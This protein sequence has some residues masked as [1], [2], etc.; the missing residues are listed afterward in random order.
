MHAEPA[1]EHPQISQIPQILLGLSPEPD[2][3]TTAKAAKSTKTD[4]IPTSPT[5][6]NPVP[7]TRA[8]EHLS[9]R[10]LLCCLQPAHCKPTLS[11]PD[12]DGRVS[13]AQTHTGARGGNG[14][15][16]LEGNGIDAPEDDEPDALG[17]N[18][19]GSP[20]DSEP[21]A[22]RGS[23]IEAS[24]DCEDRTSGGNGEEALKG[25]GTDSPGDDEEDA[26]ADNE[27]DAPGH[28][29]IE[30]STD[31]LGDAGVDFALDQLSS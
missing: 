2:S 30:D 13:P 14:P 12:A 9:T 7:R 27:V 15:D 1:E 18:G 25:N 4:V 11:R 3:R 26:P 20:G 23:G 31:G 19:T 17:G 21:D 6:R 5:R 10:A 22:L 8:L 16:A 24:G 28:N 29:G